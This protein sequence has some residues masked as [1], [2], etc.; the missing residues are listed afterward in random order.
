MTCFLYFCYLLR[1]FVVIRFLIDDV[2]CHG[3]NPQEDR[4]TYVSSNGTNDPT[5]FNAGHNN[6]CQSLSYVLNSV[7]QCD[8][9]CTVI[10]LS[11]QSGLDVSKTLNTNQ[12]LYIIGQGMI[13]IN[14]NQLI[15]NMNGTSFLSFVN[16]NVP[17]PYVK[18]C[19]DGTSFITFDNTIVTSAFIKICGFRELKL[20]NSLFQNNIRLNFTQDTSVLIE[21]TTFESQK[22]QNLPLELIIQLELIDYI[23]IKNSLFQN[24]KPLSL[25]IRNATKV[26]IEECMFYNNEA[27]Q[28]MIS[29]Q[30]NNLYIRKQISYT[31]INCVFKNN[32][33]NDIH[34]LL[35]FRFGIL[36]FVYTTYIANVP[37]CLTC[38]DTKVQCVIDITNSSILTNNGMVL[39]STDIAGCWYRIINSTILGNKASTSIVQLNSNIPQS[40]ITSGKLLV[41]DNSIIENNYVPFKTEDNNAVMFIQ[42]VTRVVMIN[43]T[44]FI[45]N[46]G[47]SLALIEC[48]LDVHGNIAFENNVAVYGGGVYFDKFASVGGKA[49][50]QFVNNTA[51]YGT[52]MYFGKNIDC[53]ETNCVQ[54]EINV[55]LFGNSVL[56][57][58]ISYIFSFSSWCKCN[59]TYHSNIQNCWNIS[60]DVKP[61][62][63][64]YA[65]NITV[66]DTSMELF[67]G[68]TIVLDINVLDCSGASSTCVAQFFGCSW[69]ESLCNYTVILND[70][71]NP[72]VSLSSGKIDTRLLIQFNNSLLGNGSLLF[73]C[74]DPPINGA[75]ATISVK[76][77]PCPVGMVYNYSNGQCVCAVFDSD[78]LLCSVQS[79]IVCIKKGYWFQQMNIDKPISC[80]HSSYCNFSMKACPSDLTRGLDYFHLTQNEDDQCRD[81]HGGTLCMNCTV[82]K[83][84]TYLALQCIDKS[85]C[86]P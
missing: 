73:K 75:N 42:C 82:N 57:G 14:F 2:E 1:I 11:S 46:T 30:A 10:V 51:Q 61:V 72:T 39:N 36:H 7:S 3:A 74:Q 20:T 43:S 38:V 78:I 84:F 13:S 17:Q 67:S 69:D 45:K 64:S 5:C 54:S 49:K 19:G 32:S 48:N 83:C 25:E 76:L 63:L 53:L 62:I 50:I 35:E 28:P 37:T 80:P 23:S 18:I 12:S 71:I 47:T 68:E 86:K 65:T 81:G 24:I 26:N 52:A 79:G 59:Q 40:M 8:T 22:S 41:I 56:R 58:S 6:P 44:R 27:W 9:N 29:L 85:L 16:I 66:S 34:S 4:A 77:V 15:I 55:T 21:N 33:V 60:Y 70:N 31:I